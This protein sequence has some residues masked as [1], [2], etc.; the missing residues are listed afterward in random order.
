MKWKFKKDKFSLDIVYVEDTKIGGFTVYFAQLPNI[1]A[2]GDTKE[3]A[4]ENLMDTIL[5]VFE[6]QKNSEIKRKG[7]RRSFSV[8]V[9]FHY[10]LYND[11]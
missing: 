6:Y 2:E 8:P 3:E 11:E 9:Q 7:G 4:E 10:P 5:T 1:I